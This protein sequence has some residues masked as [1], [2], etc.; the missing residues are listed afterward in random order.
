MSWTS[1]SENIDS[2][3]RDYLLQKGFNNTLKVFDSELKNDK[4]KG[5]KVS[6]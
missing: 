1:T 5:F 3:L 6:C 2:L 4:E